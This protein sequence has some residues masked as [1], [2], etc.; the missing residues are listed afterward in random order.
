MSGVRNIPGCD[1]AVMKKI[2]KRKINTAW[3]A[4]LGNEE[5]KEV[6]TQ[7]QGNEEERR[8]SSIST[9]LKK[10]RRNRQ[11]VRNVNLIFHLI[12]SVICLCLSYSIF[13]A[14]A[15]ISY[16]DLSFS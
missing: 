7:D 8:D 14:D 4:D 13:M 12:L 5:N 15:H 6:K 16:P 1:Q 10:G 2:L 3:K 9:A 11:A